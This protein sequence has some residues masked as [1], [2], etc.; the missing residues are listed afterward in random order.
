VKKFLALGLVFALSGP[1]V[2]LPSPPGAPQNE[3]AVPA[4]DAQCDTCD[5]LELLAN[6]DYRRGRHILELRAAKGD[7]FAVTGIGK[8]YQMGWGVPV[9]Y[10]RAMGFYQAAAKQGDLTALN[11]IGFMTL[12]GLGRPADPKAAWCWF[13]QAAEA[14]YDRSAEHLAELMAAG[15][16]PVSCKSSPAKVSNPGGIPATGLELWNGVREGMTPDQVASVLPAPFH[17]ALPQQP[18]AYSGP[19][20]SDEVFA[21]AALFG[22]PAMAMV[23]FIDHAATDVEVNM[24]LQSDDPEQY[25]SLMAALASRLDAAYGPAL[26]RSDQGMGP[27]GVWRRGDVAVKLTAKVFPNLPPSI[28]VR[29]MRDAPD[30]SA[31]PLDRSIVARR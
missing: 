14:G 1:A 10:D 15:M 23:T 4:D 18:S 20:Y 24:N 11:Q 2:A 5:A 22:F 25:R 16:Q 13:E 3:V 31:P 8:I 9:D 29:F 19:R 28:E 12:K 26:D 27:A 30:P 6:G 21:P 17:M 7:A